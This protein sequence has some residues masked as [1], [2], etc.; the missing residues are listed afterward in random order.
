[1]R[2]NKIQI[3]IIRYQLI[4]LFGIENEIEMSKSTQNRI[5]K[6]TAKPNKISREKVKANFLPIQDITS[7]S[8]LFS[9]FFHFF[10][11]I[12]TN[13][14]IFTRIILFLFIG[15]KKKIFKSGC[16]RVNKW[17]IFTQKHTDTLETDHQ[18]IERLIN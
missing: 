4:I 5:E 6:H 10:G 18:S 17:P 9:L 15:T 7:F 13:V 8:L 12:L 2:Q 14:N 11:L 3:K 1:M 16:V